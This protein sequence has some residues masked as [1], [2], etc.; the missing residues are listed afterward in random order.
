MKK[1]IEDDE[2]WEEY[3]RLKKIGKIIESIKLKETILDSYKWKKSCHHIG[4][5]IRK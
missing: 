3:Q 5:A 4:G 1:K 2:R